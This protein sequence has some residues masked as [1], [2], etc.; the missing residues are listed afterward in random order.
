M[1][2]DYELFARV[3]ASPSLSAAGRAAGLSPAMVSK[4]IARLEERLGVRL[5]HRTTRR[6]TLTEPGERFLH[7]V[8]SILASIEEAEARVAGR[9]GLVSGTLRVSAPTSFGRLHVAPHLTAFLDAHPRL[10]LEIDLSDGFVDLLA[11]RL[12]VAIRIAAQVDKG[13]LAHRL[14]TSGRVLC[15][16]PAYLARAGAPATIADFKD[17]RLLAATGQLPWT[18]DGPRGS[19]LVEG[20]S[21]VRTNSSEV[22]RELTLAGVGIALRS[23]WDVGGDLAA[24]RLVRVLEDYRG[25]A[26]V[27]IYAVQP[28]TR[29]TPPAVGA[30]IAY[31]RDL[32]AFPAPWER[33]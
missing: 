31:L 25:S 3:A 24:G 28:A 19:V 26:D 29:F 21:H 10:R 16:A 30:F 5:V 2:P 12:D 33:G 20:Q 18:L 9:A 6:L 14:S 1:D 8:R 15:A 17:H 4:R 27:G 13:L 32:Y 22:V 23:L 7:D 11:E